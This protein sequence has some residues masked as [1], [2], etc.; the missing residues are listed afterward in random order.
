[1]KAMVLEK[2]SNVRENPTPLHLR[3]LPDPAPGPGEIRIRVQTCGVCHTELDEIEGRT[4]PPRLNTAWGPSEACRRSQWIGA[5]PKTAI[6]P[7]AQ[8]R[9]LRHPTPV[10]SPLPACNAGGRTRPCGW[11]RRPH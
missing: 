6:C 5:F 9:R 3:E 10:R 2:L 8:R 1:M 4:P 11:G 7:F